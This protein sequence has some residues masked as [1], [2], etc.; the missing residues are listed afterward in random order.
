MYSSKSGSEK[1]RDAGLNVA[2]VGEGP[3]CEGTANGTEGFAARTDEDI[4]KLLLKGTAW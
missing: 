4:I 2:G 3:D 1:S